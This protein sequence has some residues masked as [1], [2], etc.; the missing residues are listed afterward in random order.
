LACSITTR[1]V[2]AADSCSFRRWASALARCWAMDRAARSAK[3]AA[4]LRLLPMLVTHLSFPEIAGEMFLF[5]PHGQVAGG[6]DLPE[7]GASSS[8]QAV[9][10]SRNLGLL[11][12]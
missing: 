4:E 9:A 6:L 7:A 2:R 8:S 12:R 10:R 3:A 5:P 11:D 1:L